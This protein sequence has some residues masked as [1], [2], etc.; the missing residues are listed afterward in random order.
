MV[1]PAR[2]FLSAILTVCLALSGMSR[3]RADDP[4]RANTAIQPMPKDE[5]RH[6]GFVAIAKKGHVDV[7][8]L[9]DS[10][11]DGW[12]V[13]AAKPIF[14][15]HFKALHAE[16]FGI[17]GDQTQHV[18]WRLKHGELQGIHPKVAMLMIG[19]NNLHGNTDGE[20]VDGVKAVVAEIHKQRPKT[21]VLLLGIFP[22]APSGTDPVRARIK[23]INEDLAKMDDGKS[24]HYLDIGD[25]FLAENGNLT[26]EIMPDFLHLSP[27]GYTIW[28][29]AVEPVIKEMMAQ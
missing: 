26:K 18:L 28:S 17:G 29:D 22:R 6:E 3:V 20:I 24:V 13:G 19:T 27:K 14:D 1:P 12:R 23:H 25:K 2:L 8:F 10:I 15:K 5:K 4:K 7:L 9:G 16:N 21:K 11:T